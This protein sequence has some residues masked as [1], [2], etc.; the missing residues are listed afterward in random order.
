MLPSPP[1][2][3]VGDESCARFTDGSDLVRLLDF[4]GV[5]IIIIK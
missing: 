1:L 4:W 5:A 3:V 2:V